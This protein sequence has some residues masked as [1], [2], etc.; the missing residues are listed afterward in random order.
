M[1]SLYKNPV[2]GL[3][4]NALLVIGS[5][6]LCIAM[7]PY[8]WD[9][10]DD[11]GYQYLSVLHYRESPLAPLTFYIG[12]LW[13][14]V[15]GDNVLSF[16]YLQLLCQCVAIGM[17][18]VWFYRRTKDSRMASLLF[19][20]LI[21]GTKLWAQNVYNWDT[22]AYPFIMLCLLATLA[23]NRRP[24]FRRGMALAA[25][26]ALMLASRLPLGVSLPFV[27][28][29]VMYKHRGH[30]G[31]WLWQLAAGTLVVAL[32]LLGLV[33]LIYGSFDSF[34]AAWSPD[35]IIN[36]HLEAVSLQRHYI[37][38]YLTSAQVAIA[39]GATV[40]A[41]GCAYMLQKVKILKGWLWTFSIVAV[42]ICQ[43]GFFITAE[44][45]IAYGTLQPLVFF[46]C[47]YGVY[48]AMRK[49]VKPSLPLSVVIVL[50]YIIIP[51]VGSDGFFER[52]LVLP[53]LPVVCAMTYARL[54]NIIRTVVILLLATAV[55]V[56]ARQLKVWTS[57]LRI[58]GET[59]SERL[60][61]TK[62]ADIREFEVIHH[63]HEKYGEDIK[64][65]FIGDEMVF[66]AYVFNDDIIFNRHHYHLLD[67]NDD[68]KYI[69]AAIADDYVFAVTP[70]MS[71]TYGGDLIDYLTASGYRKTDSIGSTGIFEKIER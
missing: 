16:R 36:G 62:I 66:K 20:M 6:A 7:Q 12:H 19:A 51:M 25:A 41:L 44:F 29:L 43:L 52:L 26:W 35:N 42:S 67:I 22:G 27:I 3:I 10:H 55:I 17:G 37:R 59:V 48:D 18:V 69:D 24:D 23:Y 39:W 68:K 15:A 60:Q 2:S 32:I 49:G 50:V 53:T 45:P 9:L 63:I 28:W 40:A 57:S 54:K 58:P 31:E 71:T 5:L 4:I 1:K 33:Y 30:R 8:G 21:L 46:L 70:R 64:F 65:K 61:G 14:A 34:I 13:S 38:F 47:F 11:E 56:S